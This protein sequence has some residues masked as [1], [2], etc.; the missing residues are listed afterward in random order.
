MSTSSSNLGQMQRTGGKVPC[1]Q[2]SFKRASLVTFKMH[3]FDNRSRAASSS[4]SLSLRKTFNKPKQVN[5]PLVSRYG[6]CSPLC[7]NSMQT[8]NSVT[9]YFMKKSFSDVSRKWILP[10]MI[11]SVN[12]PNHIW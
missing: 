4:P 10:N 6:K 1:F 2:N 8:C 7:M 12:R 11:R 9:F 3:E 5:H